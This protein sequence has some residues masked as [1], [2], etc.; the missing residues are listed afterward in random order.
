MAQEEEDY[1]TKVFKLF[2]NLKYLD[3]ADINNEED[4]EDDDEDY[5]V[6]GA[7]GEEDEEDLDDEEDGEEE[8]DGEGEEDGGMDTGNTG[9]RTELFDP[10]S[11]THLEKN[12][13]FI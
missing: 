9:V 5:G 12:N 6:N 10:S 4:D 2:P 13:L 11:L 7:G 8:E 3:G 1:R